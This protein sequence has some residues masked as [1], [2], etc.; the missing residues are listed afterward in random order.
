MK[1]DAEIRKDVLDELEWEPRINATNVGVTIK[2]GIVTLN[3]H[4]NTYAEKVA[5]E[6]A[7][8][9]VSGVKA[10]VQEIDVNIEGTSERTDQ[11]IALAA[12]D[13][14][15]WNTMVSDKDIQL[16]VENGWITL[17]GELAWNYQVK[18]ATNAVKN[19]PGVRGV[20]NLIKVKVPVETPDV[21][22]KIRNAFERNAILDAAEVE[23]SV[24]GHEVILNGTVQSWAEMKQAENAAWSA[25]GV[26]NVV[27]H[28]K[29]KMRE[30]AY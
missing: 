8:K 21:K 6:E 11:A 27:N 9:R 15:K 17:E 16:K 19:L 1:T 24:E 14:L 25:P 4:V 18:A 22:Q 12:V 20:T 26:S 28:L 5:A 30:Y 3:G 23:V 2:N 29:I 13:S 7:A 10:V